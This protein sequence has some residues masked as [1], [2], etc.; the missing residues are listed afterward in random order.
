[1]E[2]R[3]QVLEEIIREAGGVLAKNYGNPQQ[4]EYKGAV[5]LVTAT[6]YASED[7]IISRLK[8]AFPEDDILAEEREAKPLHSEGLWIVDPLDGTNNYAHGFPMF[9]VSIGYAQAG[10]IRLGAVYD[11]LRDE[12]F[13]AEEGKGATLNGSPFTVSSTAVL[14]ASLVATGFPYD[15]R[16]S[17]I[18]NLDHFQRFAL[19]VQ[20]VRRGGSAALD[21]AYV[22]VGHLDGFWELK[23]SPWDVAAGALLVREAGGRITD[24]SGGEN[25]LYGGEVVAS[26]A[27]IHEEMLGTLKEGLTPTK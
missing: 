23:L 13:V 26:N 27:K 4:I 2:K 10:R 19:R 11:P 14:D 17:P 7:L 1:L 20:G 9:C 6:D 24:F 3:R 22:A 5:N 12:L 16:E 25:F 18:N 15:K 21:L 8:A